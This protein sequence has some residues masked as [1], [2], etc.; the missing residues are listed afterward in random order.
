[1]LK[2]TRI[3]LHCQML[4]LLSIFTMLCVLSFLR[5]DRGP[6]WSEMRRIIHPSTHPGIMLFFSAWLFFSSRHQFFHSYDKRTTIHF[7]SSFLPLCLVSKEHA[8]NFHQGKCA[9]R[10]TVVCMRDMPL[11]FTCPTRSH[12]FFP[13]LFVLLWSVKYRHWLVV[14]RLTTL[15]WIKRQ[16]YPSVSSFDLLY[17]IYNTLLLLCVIFRSWSWKNLC[18]RRRTLPWTS[19]DWFFLANNCKLHVGHSYFLYVLVVDILHVV[20]I[21]IMYNVWWMNTCAMLC[22]AH[23]RMNMYNL[24]IYPCTMYIASCIQWLCLIISL[25]LCLS[26]ICEYR[27]DEK[28]LESYGISAGDIVHMVIQLRGGGGGGEEVA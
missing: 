3:D 22:C 9:E 16:V 25:S 17:L 24:R 14:S 26:L 10:Y 15:K 28:S 18:R 1:M 7:L 2:W 5:P 12:S 27:A 21:I 6:L 13:S 11:F 8:S 23:K 20:V 4:W 19:C